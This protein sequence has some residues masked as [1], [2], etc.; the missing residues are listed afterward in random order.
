MKATA[1]RSA[2]EAEVMAMCRWSRAGTGSGKH[3]VA[4]A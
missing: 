4:V 3:S 2:A 1:S